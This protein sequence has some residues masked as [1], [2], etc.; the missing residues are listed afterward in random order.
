[1]KPASQPAQLDFEALLAETD[2]RNASRSLEAKAAHLPATMDEAVPYFRGLIA[3]HHAAMLAADG[4]TVAAVRDEAELLATKLNGF[5]AGYLADRDAPGCVLDRKTRARKGKVPLWGQ[6]GAFEITVSGMRIWIAMDGL[7]GVAHS[8]TWGG[9]AAHALDWDKPFISE[10]GYRSFLGVGGDLAPDV[11][12]DAF[13]KA[14]IAEH[15]KRYMKGK[16]VAIKPEYRERA[17]TA[18]VKR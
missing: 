4:E 7:F 5:E 1:M 6:S 9:F 2:R 8:T 12:P 11:T 17:R 18:S 10:T 3:K 14:I 13:A 16:L 15:I